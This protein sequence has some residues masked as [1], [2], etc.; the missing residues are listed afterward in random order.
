MLE[1]GGASLLDLA[2]PELFGGPS[3]SAF[4]PNA[5]PGACMGRV[6]SVPGL[7]TGSASLQL[8]DAL[9]DVGG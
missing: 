4:G 8:L 6:V 7:W 3:K 1:F 9:E 2:F 5:L